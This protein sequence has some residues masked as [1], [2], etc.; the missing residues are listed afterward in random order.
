MKKIAVIGPNQALCPSALYDLGVELGERIAA[1]ERVIICGGLGGFME[2]VCK[3]VKQS[4]HTFSGQTIGILPG[5]RAQDANP[6]IDVAIPTGMG[7]ARN[8]IIINSADIIIA[9]GGGSGTLSELAFAWQKGKTVLCITQF[10]GWSQE[11]AGKNL[12]SR[13]G[14]QLIPVALLAEIERIITNFDV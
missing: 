4:S 8:I 14:G 2:A 10:G 5:D 12:D 6:Y 9:A 3:G 1:R 13:E 11:L 7:I